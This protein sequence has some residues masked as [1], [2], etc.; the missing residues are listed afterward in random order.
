M[1]W[2]IKLC[3]LDQQPEPSLPQMRRGKIRLSL[4][5]FEWQARL[6]QEI[7]SLLKKK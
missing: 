6:C 4:E 3:T 5:K 2:N 1:H 7:C